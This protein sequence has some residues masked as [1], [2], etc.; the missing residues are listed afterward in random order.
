MNFNIVID[1]SVAVKW[2]IKDESEVE[3][4]IE[5]LLDYNSGKVGFIEP[6][7]FYYETSNAVNVAVQ[8][9]R[10]TEDEGRDIIK[11]ML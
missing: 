11:D 6:Q 9:K 10:I 2:H 8:R 1:A 5:I 4:A 3:Q 7:L